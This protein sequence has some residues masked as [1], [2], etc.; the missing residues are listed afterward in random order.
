[1]SQTN[2]SLQMR[3]FIAGAVATV[4]L[5]LIILL[6]FEVHSL[7]PKADEL[8]RRKALPY[9]GQFQPTVKVATLTGDS[10]VL[11]ETT[12]GRGQLLMFF[13][14][15]CPICKRTVPSWKR[16]SERL[17]AD[18]ARRFDVVW[19][20]LSSAD[21]AKRWVAE[22]RISDPVVRMPNSKM[23]AVYRIKGVPITLLLDEQG[24]VAYM[25]PSF[26]ASVMAEDSLVNTA[27]AMRG[28]QRKTAPAPALEAAMVP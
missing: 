7:R 23:L 13:T 8:R 9:V 4:M 22:Q 1:M 2:R 5:A 6:G 27:F 19:V 14:A 20:S 28:R 18:V 26:Y 11:G 25:H 12:F 17:H 15:T 10:I 21:S 24:Q 3:R 16:I